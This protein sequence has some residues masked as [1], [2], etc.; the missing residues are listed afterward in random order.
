MEDEKDF[1]VNDRRGASRPEP[2]AGET[3]LHPSGRGN[4]DG[5]HLPEMDFSSFIIF[6]A[7]TAQM[8]L[9]SIP[10][11]E[12]GKTEVNTAA[13]RQM[14]DILG[15]LQDKT[16]GNRSEEEDQ[17]LEQVLF[18]LRMHHV[19]VSEEQKKSGRE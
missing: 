2:A 16:R 8:N 19:R 17:L 18:N 15:M 13:A 6:L 10:H 11:P 9:G 4:D 1:N 7:T 14:I 5:E 12:T 3:A